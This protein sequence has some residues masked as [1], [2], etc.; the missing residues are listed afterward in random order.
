VIKSLILNQLPRL[1]AEAEDETKFHRHN[2]DIWSGGFLFMNYNNLSKVNLREREDSWS[3]R[4]N[5][6][7]N[8]TVSAYFLRRAFL[9]GLTKVGPK[10][11]DYISSK[12]IKS[13]KEI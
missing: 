6:Q 12:I 4:N 8:K 3:K 13:K 2:K 1:K 9:F 10:L 5:F 11:R 7:D